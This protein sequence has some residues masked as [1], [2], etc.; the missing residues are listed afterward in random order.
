MRKSKK[1]ISLLLAA[2][3]ALSLGACGSDNKNASTSPEPEASQSA[4]ASNE[5]STG[6]KTVADGITTLD[7]IELGVDYT[8]V[9]AS[10]KLLT[11]R[12]DLTDNVFL[13]YAE[14][15]KELYPNIEV[16]FEG[17]TDYESSI[18]TRLT[19]TDWGDICL[20]P[21]TVDKSELSTY[22]TPMGDLDTLSEKYIM[23]ND[24]AY[25]GT[26]YGIPCAGNVQGIVYNKKVFEEAG[27]TE[28]PKTPDDF[29]A[30]LQLIKD[31]TDAIPLYTNYHAQ[32]TM[33]AWDAYIGGTSNG[34]PDYKN[35]QLLHGKDP[36]AKQDGMYGP[37]A[38][39]YVLYESVARGLIE[40][41]PTTTDWE[42]CKGEINNG[43]I[44]TMVLGSWAV[45]QMQ[46]AGDN[47]DDIG[48]MPF[49]ISIDG[50]QYTTAGPDYAYGINA[51]ASTE[52]QIASLLFTKWLTEESNYAF[53]QGGIPIVDGAEYPAVLDAF[54]GAELIID[55]PAPEGEEDLFTNVNNDSEVGL[56][57]DNI[58]DCE[59][60][61]HALAGDMTLDEIMAEWNAKWTQGQEDND[62]EIRY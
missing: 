4:D 21:T 23:L 56:N 62:V 48:Y 45:V 2:T 20:I 33:G 42:G 1:V 31:N 46:Q 27:I 55:N 14:R 6:P 59:I 34:D 57:T 30:A 38:V 36:F 3:M 22:F 35:N 18:T 40:D 52:N 28:I 41:D 39:Y 7:Q 50:K 44:G 61:E 26:V 43:N 12:T 53:D 32:W 49:P 16:T 9:S 47:P 24:K 25:D 58:P 15:F 19:T 5:G 10:I 54:T 29:L 37:Y 60:L 17:I 8:D 13:E 11:C 51:N